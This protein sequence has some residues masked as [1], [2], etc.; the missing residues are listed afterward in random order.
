MVGD[1]YP[2]S[3]VGLVLLEVP[4]KWEGIIIKM[5]SYVW[6]HVSYILT[7]FQRSSII[8]DWDIQVSKP[9]PNNYHVHMTWKDL[10]PEEENHLWCPPYLGQ[11]IVKLC[12]SPY[13]VWWIFP[14]K[15]EI[16]TNY[17]I[18]DNY[19]ESAVGLVLLEVP[20]KVVL[21]ANKILFFILMRRVV[22]GSVES[23]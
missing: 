20:K 15:K 5:S 7:K 9:N 16:P 17:L 11:L 4:E 12:K 6:E 2:Q 14:P 19:P 23:I 1:N 21:N 3:P 10:W 8:I 13:R 18:G 22:L